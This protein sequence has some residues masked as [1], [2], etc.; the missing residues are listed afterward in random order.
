LCYPVRYCDDEFG[1]F[2]CIPSEIGMPNVIAKMLPGR[3]AA[4]CNHLASTNAYAR[5]VQ[6]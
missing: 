5:L 4:H 3:S 6:S 2:N 1:G